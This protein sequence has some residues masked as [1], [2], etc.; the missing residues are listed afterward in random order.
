MRNA[1]NRSTSTAAAISGRPLA[2]PSRYTVF[3][4]ASAAAL[5]E[6]TS[7][8]PAT[9]SGIGVPSSRAAHTIGMPS[10]TTRDPR[11]ISRARAASLE[12][13]NATSTLTGIIEPPKSAAQAPRTASSTPTSLSESNQ[14]PLTSTRPAGGS[15]EFRDDAMFPLSHFLRRGEG[16]LEPASG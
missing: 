2:P 16:A 12:A 1:G 6:K 8:D 14:R 9:R 5:K 4:S 15:D 10:A 7:E 11:S 3:R 13:A